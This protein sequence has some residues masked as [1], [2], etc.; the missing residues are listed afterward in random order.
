MAE[1]ETMLEAMAE[2]LPVLP[3]PLSET[4]TGWDP[5]AVTEADIDPEAVTEPEAD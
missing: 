1:P 4:E 3:L 5:V 2:P